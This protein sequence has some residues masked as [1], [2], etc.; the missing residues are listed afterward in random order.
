MEYI[1]LLL[2][3]MSGFIIMGPYIQNGIQGYF[4]RS[5]ESLAHLRQHDPL[6]TR[7][8]IW[9]E[10]DKNWYSEKC[11]V[12]ELE[13]QG[14]RAQDADNTEKTLLCRRKGSIALCDVDEALYDLNGDKVKLEKICP[15]TCCLAEARKRCQDMCK[16][17]QKMIKPED[18][19]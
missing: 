4:R 2:L 17:F 9:D 6:K 15:T 13:E 10:R 19:D 14:C 7:D 3:I 16:Y 12:H 1:V 8:C 5:G 11:F 18:D